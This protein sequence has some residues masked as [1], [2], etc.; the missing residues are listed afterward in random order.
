MSVPIERLE[1]ELARLGD[2]H[3][4]KPGW[5]A[6][7]LAAT[8]EARPARRPWWQFAIPALVVVAAVVAII[9]GTREPAPPA[10]LALAVHIDGGSAV[11]R[12]TQAK[13]NDGMRATATGGKHRAVWI[14]RGDAGDLVLACP[15]H[16][17]CTATPTS[18]TAAITLSLPG[19]YVVV[20]LDSDAPLPAPTGSYDADVSRAVRAGARR[21]EESIEVR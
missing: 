5:Q 8:A 12:G 14:F 2:T 13:I 10:P 16:R 9:I 18:L 17:D 11:V 19:K 20:A 15:G 21:S 3:E 1:S 6:R 7:V 4:P